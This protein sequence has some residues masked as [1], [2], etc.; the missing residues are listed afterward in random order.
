MQSKPPARKLDGQILAEQLRPLN[1]TLAQ[2]LSQMT[3]LSDSQNFP[4][5]NGNPAPISHSDSGPFSIPSLT[6]DLAGMNE[7]LATLRA[8][9]VAHYMLSLRRDLHQHLGGPLLQSLRC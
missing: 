9:A 2:I 1:E 7:Q 8:F 3:T 4:Q 5:A 6:A